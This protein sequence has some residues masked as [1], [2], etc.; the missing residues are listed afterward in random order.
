MENIVR[1]LILGLCLFIHCT[2]A[3]SAQIAIIVDDLGYRHTD[4]QALA[5][6]PEIT[7]SVLPYTPLGVSLAKQAHVK[8][9]EIMVHLP[10]QAL[11]GKKLGPGGLTNQMNEQQIKAQVD[12]A[13]NNVPFAI[14]ANN[15]M[16][17]LLTQMPDSMNWVMQSLRQHDVFFVDSRTTKY[18]KVAQAAQQNDV[19]LL[20]RQVFFDND[21]HAAALE[22]EFEKIMRRSKQM[23]SL[24]VIAH[25]HPKTI[26]FLQ[27]NLPRLAQSGIKLVPTSE[28]LPYHLANKY[29]SKQANQYKHKERG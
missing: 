8:G 22:H 24:L 5:L 29:Q 15:H 6:P 9:H 23:G 7:F 25:P 28:L 1:L 21:T 16:G 2:V 3:W 18:S 17:S 26:E 11:S 14:G 19:P 12:L 10:M 27:K 20:T 13:I 4:K